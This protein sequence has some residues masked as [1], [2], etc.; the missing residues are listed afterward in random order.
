MRTLRGI[1]RFAAKIGADNGPSQRLF[2]A[3]GFQESYYS[4]VFR[5]HVYNFTVDDMSG[6]ASLGMCQDVHYQALSI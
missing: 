5:E 4:E 3:L 1:V 6:G 2:E